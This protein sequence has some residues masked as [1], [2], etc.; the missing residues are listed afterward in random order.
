MLF[1]R[2]FMPPIQLLCALEAAARHQSFTAAAR[3]LALTQG[4]VSR[5]IRALEEML[6]ADLFYREHQAV[7]LTPAGEI[8]AREIR[9]TLARLATATRGVRA[10][11]QGESLSILAPTT[12]A[13]RWLVPRLPQFLSRYPEIR[14]NIRSLAP[15]VDQE[16]PSAD[17]IITLGMPSWPQAEM[18]ALMHETVIPVCSP[19][20]KQKFEFE[21]SGDLLKAP[22]IHLIY[23][24]DDWRRWFSTRNAEASVLPGMHFDHITIAN[25]AAQAGLGTALLPD[26]FIKDELERGE[27]VL[28]LDAPMASG[29]RYFFA[30]SKSKNEY[31]P[32][33]VFRNWLVDEIET[34]KE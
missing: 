21:V 11:P 7:F 5:Q 16:F 23:R 22:L 17:G 34:L 13:G 32:T 33:Q 14:I 19:S 24:P 25:Q 30:W 10:S 15:T 8:Y 1:P 4:A 12:F 26:H 27:L 28:A 3:E 31:G 18:V 6:G 29:E 9:E 20:L 2:R